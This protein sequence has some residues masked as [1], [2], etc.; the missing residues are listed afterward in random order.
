[1]SPHWF[2]G[3]GKHRSSR[4]RFPIGAHWLQRSLQQYSPGWQVALPQG[5]GSHAIAVQG[6]SSGRQMP[7][8]RRQQTVPAAQR[9]RAHGFFLGVRTQMPPQSAPP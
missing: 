3:S 5:S 1:V 2:V 6:T 9:M 8:Q 4:Q 7:P